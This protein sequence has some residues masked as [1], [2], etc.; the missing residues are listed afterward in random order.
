MTYSSLQ[1]V[2]LVSADGKPTPGLV[3]TRSEGPID[4]SI[5]EQAAIINAKLFSRIDFVFFRR[6][7]DG[8][9][10]QIAAYIVDNSNQQ[11]NE[12]ALAE[13]HQ[14]VWLQGTAPLLYVAW[15][16]RIDILTCARG[17]DFWETEDR[18]CRY[19]PAL[20]L[21]TA[22]EIN[23]ELQK[24]SALRLA[25]GTFWEDSDN[26]KLVDHDRAAHQSLIQAV[27]DTDKDLDGERN[28][29]LRRLLLLM[30]LIKYLEDRRVFPNDWF[31]TFHK[32]A[33]K[34]SDVLR[35]GELEEVEQLLVSLE[36]KFNGDIFILPKEGR[37]KLTK[38]LLKRIAD[39]VDA[40]M[41]NRQLCLWAQF[42][43]E[44][45]PV[46][47]ISHLYQRFV[48][49][50]HGTVYT[51]PFLSSLLLDHAM[52]Y[53]RLTGEERILDPACGS[54]IF[55]VGVFRRLINVWRSRNRW[56]RPD[57]DTL[58]MI[59]KRS[60]YGIELDPNAIELTAFSLSLAICDALQPEIIWNDLKF[61]RLRESNL[62]EADFFRL[63]LDSQKGEPTIFEKGFDV[64]IGNPPFESKLSTA[65]AEINQN[66]R[67]QDNSRGPL[68]D[69]QTAYLF[70][71]QALAV[72]PPGG[73]LC[74]IQPSGLLYNRNVQDFWIAL[75]R[76]Y[77]IETV[78]DFTSIRKLY[79]A[80]PK[81]VAVF[82]RDNAPSE[83]HRINH[84]TFRR[85]VS[86]HERICFELDHYDRH[87][88]LQKQAETD[89]HVWRAN[90]LG[91][92][93]LL[94]MSQRLRSMRTLA[95]YVKQQGWDY[96]EGF[97]AAKTG[98]REPAP[99]LTGKPF[100]PTAAFT[101]SGIDETQIT[102][103]EETHFRSAY[104]E[105]R[106]SAPLVLI[107]ETDSLPVTYWDKG[108]LG[109]RHKIVGIHAPKSQ[110]SELGRLYEAFQLNHD[111]YRFSS[112]LNG[113]QSLVG[114]ATAILKQDIDIL[115]YPEDPRRLSY[116]FWEQALCEEVLRY[117]T[118]YVRLGQNSELLKAAA[119]IS[120]LK[121]YSSMFIRLLGSVYDNLKGADPVFLNGLTCQPFYFGEKPN[122]AWLEKQNGKELQKLV[123]DEQ[124]HG[125]LR[126]IRIMRFY[127]E[128]VFLLV[129]PD[130][131][132]YWIRSTAI[133]D[134]DETLVDLRR[135]GY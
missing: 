39:L 38:T 57:V 36:H 97:I 53:G 74:M 99:F 59:L 52:P 15:S 34:F 48:K 89:R 125:S 54:G 79:E 72:L 2:S 81:T 98:K 128:N 40:K 127:S 121:E 83:E 87:R 4:L 95:E 29:I 26:R 8:R 124:M 134:A 49:G 30:V 70:L 20:M 6:F 103:V 18:E 23:R 55:L 10:S 122:L 68:P 132:R 60:I 47:I 62:F 104:T 126:T 16:S 115:P 65:G 112:T 24:F 35:G 75:H 78:F 119:D 32:G 21:Q 63:L 3:P 56:Q 51:P 113:T 43:F 11:L 101:D 130:R 91:G 118:E 1:F 107:K 135:Q 106:Y 76:K 9:S 45:L 114:K 22:G 92:G 77:Q 111:I 102:V 109:Y 100:L 84:W 94:D 41:L 80:D 133:R 42:S 58:K 44:H 129:K 71:E 50:G 19:M 46:E 37:Q 5:D 117:M 96:G 86:V 67:R 33:K 27:V 25:D 90:L 28:P 14:Q 105:A 88:V 69:N 108:F 82:A 73:R 120:D 85:T 13:L 131:L 12:K 93:R 123:Y 116:S 61:Y 64:I 110:A 31:G 66:E 7:S 17:P